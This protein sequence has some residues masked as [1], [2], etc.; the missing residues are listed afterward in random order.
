MQISYVFFKS[1]SILTTQLPIIHQPTI[2][3]FS[4]FM[5]LLLQGENFDGI[6]LNDIR[7]FLGKRKCNLQSIS[8]S[9]GN[10][11]CKVET[12]SSLVDTE[13]KV[14]IEVGEW[15]SI[16]LGTLR[17]AGANKINRLFLIIGVICGF[18]LIGLLILC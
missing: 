17:Y 6:T 9:S 1:T 5:Q 8:S 13:V 2:L 12:D 16:E 7:L 4:T 10:L 15:V 14:K 18:F 11:F 3:N